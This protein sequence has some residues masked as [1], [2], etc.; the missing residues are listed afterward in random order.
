VKKHTTILKYVG[1]DVHKA[2]VSAA[3]ADAEGGEVRDL[4]T[5]SHELH[6]IGTVLHKLGPPGQTQVVY[7]DR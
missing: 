2:T 4:G 7:E 6:A 5:V 3:V 1:L